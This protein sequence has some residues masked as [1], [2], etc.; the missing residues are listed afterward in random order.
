MR[1][2]EWDADK[3][4]EALE[5]TNFQEYEVTKMRVH[6]EFSP[7]TVVNN[8]AVLEVAT[9]IDLRTNNNVNAACFPACDGMFDYKFQN[10]T[11]TR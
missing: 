3:F 10:G 7:D 11:G 1:V 4:D 9:P 5:V 8:L 2:G 6:P